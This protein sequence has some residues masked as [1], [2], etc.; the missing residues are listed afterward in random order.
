MIKQDTL[1]KKL[2]TILNSDTFK[3]AIK[4]LNT[5]EL[6]AI[7]DCVA[8]ETLLDPEKAAI[9]LAISD[10]ELKEMANNVALEIPHKD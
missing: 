9:R 7:L 10:A 8:L 6:C 1:K 3:Y 4:K 2:G 5:D